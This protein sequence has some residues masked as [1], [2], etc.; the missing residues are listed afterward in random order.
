M[1]IFRLSSASVASLALMEHAEIIFGPGLNVGNVEGS[2]LFGGGKVR[3]GNHHNQ[4]GHRCVNIAEDAYD[5]GAGET[6]DRVPP[7]E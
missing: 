6:H 3:A 7:G 2:I 5:A 1:V 4:G